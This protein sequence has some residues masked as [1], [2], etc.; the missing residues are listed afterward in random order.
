MSDGVF[1]EA[2]VGLVRLRVLNVGG[3]RRTRVWSNGYIIMKV[4]LTI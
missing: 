1:F 4:C 3:T 2:M